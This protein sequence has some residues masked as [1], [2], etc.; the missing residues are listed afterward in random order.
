MK[1]KK[2]ARVSNTH[3]TSVNYYGFIGV[4][5]IALFWSCTVVVAQSTTDEMPEPPLSDEVD[6]ES[7]A[8]DDSTAATDT[9][10]TNDEA[11][12]TSDT[13]LSEDDMV[14]ISVTEG[15]IQDVL[16]S[17]AAM[18]PETTIMIDPEVEGEVSFEIQDMPW[19]MAIQLV[20]DSHGLEIIRRSDNVYL[21]KPKE[22]VVE[23]T[24]DL[25]L[26]LY[27]VEEILELSDAQLRNMYE[28]HPE[29]KEN[30]SIQEIRQ[31]VSEDPEN[32]IIRL[33]ATN[34]PPI[35]VINLL[36]RKSN[37][38]FVFSSHFEP[39]PDAENKESAN[40]GNAPPSEVGTP[41]SLNIR[42]R[43]IPVAIK[44]I[45]NQGGLSAN[46]QD[47]IWVV[48]PLQPEQMAKEPLLSQTFRVK[49]IPIDEKLITD[50]ESL[51]SERGNVI[52]RG[53]VLSVFDT[54]ERLEQVEQILADQDLPTPQVLIESRFFV[55][56][57][58]DSS[59][60][61]INWNSLTNE[62]SGGL[63]FGALP[64]SLTYD[65]MEHE[66]IEDLRTATLDLPEL[67]ATLHAL[68]NSDNARQLSNPKIIVNSDEQASIHIGRQ[69]PIIKSTIDTSGETATTTFELDTNFGG[70]TVSVVDLLGDRPGASTHNTEYSGYTGYLDLGT[71]LTV[72]PS[73]KTEDEVYIRVIP[74]LI[75]RPGEKR[76]GEQVFPELFRIRVQTQFSL[77]SGETIALG[78]LVSEDTQNAT[79]ALP[80]LGKIPLLGKLFRYDTEET[81]RSETVIFLTVRVIWPDELDTVSAVPVNSNQIQ[82]E[83]DKIRIQDAE[84]GVYN[85]EKIKER[86]RKLEEERGSRLFFR[87]SAEEEEQ[88]TSKEKT[89]VV[90]PFSEIE[91]T[92]IDEETKQEEAM[93]EGEASMAE[94]DAYMNMTEEETSVTEEESDSTEEEEA[95]EESKE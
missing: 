18:R 72:A 13:A 17:L 80:F 90:E 6:E 40:A 71:K 78:G 50:I 45:A 22:D 95:V 44:L 48:K 84:G 46:Y 7:A 36:A 56:S 82:P 67:N 41:V 85:E 42:N 70:D 8:A 43:S 11:I 16:R 65:Y 62:E 26:E 52:A 14:S 79:N 47:G 58:T 91:S 29:T 75:N 25:K 81:V 1:K 31:I 51:M 9:E 23:E 57:D 32:Y 55:L 3:L 27:T 60:L 61:G 2:N 63:Q 35:E 92:Q 5:M 34:K 68:A 21:V 77:K 86:L 38:D 33:S 87:E 53:K 37:I 66:V 88:E 76:L 73:V 15:R 64:E 93:T 12:S 39:D 49:Y 4:L 94:E 83:I 30:K 28:A 20:A 10:D 89:E 54:A 69:E 19:E 74:E 59:G 24:A